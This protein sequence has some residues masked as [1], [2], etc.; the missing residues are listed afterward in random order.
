VLL[1][2]A[3]VPN[4]WRWVRRKPEIDPLRY[5]ALRVVDD[6]SYG[7]GVWNGARRNGRW[8]AITPRFD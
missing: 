4:L 2:S 1:V 8:E 3:V 5:V 7:A 6:A